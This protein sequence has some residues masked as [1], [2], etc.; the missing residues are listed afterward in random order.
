M[1]V[2][3]ANST[4]RAANWGHECQVIQRRTF[5]CFH[6]FLRTRSV[7]DTTFPVLCGLIIGRVVVLQLQWISLKQMKAG[8]HKHKILEQQN[9]HN[10]QHHTQGQT[11]WKR[12]KRF[13][14]GGIALIIT[15]VV[16]VVVGVTLGGGPSSYTWKMVHAPT[17]S[18]FYYYELYAFHFI[19]NHRPMKMINHTL[20]SSKMMNL[21]MAGS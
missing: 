12:H 16:A 14:I 8:L 11:H 18:T 21:K 5:G 13:V 1:L 6:T 10:G 9:I 3:N 20:L 7:D 2:T 17:N 15:I 4:L 19:N